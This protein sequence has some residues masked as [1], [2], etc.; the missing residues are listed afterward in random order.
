MILAVDGAVTVAIRDLQVRFPSGHYP[1]GTPPVEGILA[2]R[3]PTV[4]IE[5]VLVQEIH[6]AT[7]SGAQVGQCIRAG[8]FVSPNSF[9]GGTLTVRDSTVRYCQKTGILCNEAGTVCTLENNLIELGGLGDANPPN[10]PRTQTVLAPNGIQFGFGARGTI[11]NN[12]V[13]RFQCELPSPQCGG[14]LGT[15]QF[16]SCGILLYLNGAATA[17]LANTVETSDDGLCSY[18]AAPGSPLDLRDNVVRN[19]R[20]RSM[21]TAWGTSE[22]R[23]NQLL[24]A[25]HGILLL[26]YGGCDATRVRL[27]PPATPATANRIDGASVNGIWLRSFAGNAGGACPTPS[28]PGP[29]AAFITGRA[30]RIVNN[31]VAGLDNQPDEGDADLPCNWWGSAQGP[32]LG[33]ANP[34]LTSPGDVVSP[35]AVNDVDFACPA[36]GPTITVNASKTGPATVTPGVPFTWTLTVGNA[37]PAD[38][39]GTTVSDPVPAGISSFSWTCS[40]AGG[41][42]CPAASGT[43]AINV[44]IAVFPPGGSLTFTITAVLAPGFA[45]A[46]NEAT[47]DPRPAVPGSQVV[48]VSSVVGLAP[49][50]IPAAGAIALLGLAGLVMLAAALARPGRA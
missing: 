47:I 1:P 18:P 28:Q 19:N 29:P 49:R 5:R 26:G 9:P 44:T 33:G 39:S 42:L 7:V 16:A 14:N 40:A 43:G 24:G 38:G 37:G 13:R 22:L 36:G 30:N 46:R 12:T 3:N 8:R 50:A 23:G 48:V 4:T 41:A 20:W 45:F 15:D 10:P 25:Q 17:L 35:H 31:A 21:I 11:R 27:N 32:G 6:D 34:A 2:V